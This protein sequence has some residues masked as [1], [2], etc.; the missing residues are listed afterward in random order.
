MSTTTLYEATPQ[1]GTV[2]TTNL[3]SLYSNNTAFTSGVVNSSVYSVNG[4][5]GVTVDPTTGNVLVSIGQPVAT[6]DNVTFANVTATGNIATNGNLTLNA[7]QGPSNSV[8]T[9]NYSSNQ[10]SLFWDG[11][12]WN[13]ANQVTIED[14]LTQQPKGVQGRIAGNDYWFVG[15]YS[16][17]GSSS[18]D[19][20]MVIASGNNGDEPIYVR[21]YTGS[22][23]PFPAGNTITRQL[24]LLDASGNTVLPVSLQLNGSTSGS[25]KIASPAI[26][27]TQSYTLPTALPASNGYVLSSTT[28]GTLSWVDKLSGDVVGPASATDNALTRFD[29]T[30]GKLIQN[31]NAILSD[32]GDLSIAGDLTVTGNDIKSSSATALT[33]SGADVAVAG[34]LTVTGQD[35]TA[36]SNNIII[37]RDVG[38]IS[39]VFNPLTLRMT[40]S[41]TPA[42]GIGTSLV[43]ETETAVGV[44]TQAG[45]IQLQST[46]ITPGSESFNMNFR[47]R[48]AGADIGRMTLDN[49]GNLQFDGDL[50]V[51]GND[52]KSSSATALTLSG[53]NVAIAGDL[54]VTGNDIKSSSA[55]ALTLSGANVAIAGDLTV[56]GNDIK[57]SSATALTLSGANVAIAGDLTVTGG[58]VT[59]AGST[60]GTVALNAPAIAGTQNYTLP[61]ALPAS[62]GYVLSSTTGGVMSWTATAPGAGDVVGPASA[63]DNALARFDGTTGKLI[64]NSTAILSDTGDLSISG[65]L[66]VTGQDITAG[67]NNIIIGRNVGATGSIFYPLTSRLTT[68]GTPAVGIGTGL[69]FETETAVG[70]NTQSGAIQL[71]STSIT[72]GSES[73]NMNFR[74]ISSGVD[75]NRM[76][77]DNTGNLQIDGDLTVSGNDIKSSSATA[78]T[79]SGANV[80]VIGTLDVQG[81]TITRSTGALNITTGAA[82]GDIT[83]DPNG[84][85]NIVCTLASGGNLTNTTNYLRGTVGN[86]T[87]LSNGDIYGF[88]SGAATSYRGALITNEDNTAKAPGVILR[89]Y[90]GGSFGS[91]LTRPQFAFER[92]RGTLASPTALQSGDLIGGFSG[93]GYTST[94]WLRDISGATTFP[95][96]INLS[97]TENW[98][99]NTNVGTGFSVVLMPSATTYT[100]PGVLQTSLSVNPQSSSIR[101]DGLVLQNK[102]STS[103]VVNFN[104]SARSLTMNGPS[105]EVLLLAGDVNIMQ[106]ASTWQSALSPGF[107]YTGLMSSSTQTNTGSYFEMSSRWKAS[108]GTS[109]YS[110]P[111]SGWGLGRF[112]F[113]A[114]VSTTGTSQ[115]NAGA[116]QAIATENWD[117]THYGSK[118]VFSAYKLGTGGV[119]NILDM[120]PE[121]TTITSDAITLESSSGADYLVLNANTA[122]FSVP[123]TT[124]LTS[125]TISEGT[126]YT[127]AA[128]VNN[129]LNIQ[130][131]ALAGGTTV[132][133]LANLTGNTR[134]ASYNILVFNNTGTGTPIQVKNTRI[135]TNNLMTH[136]ITT[137][138]R[139]II[140][141]YVVGDYA[142]ATHLQIP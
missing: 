87:V 127:P 14:N 137:G 77:L 109:T 138:N 30:T 142:T 23:T 93:N 74:L 86:S 123:V 78:L 27:G 51:T 101:T 65:D 135:N 21:Q 76:V 42:V 79:L 19:G 111:Q 8:I 118:L 45:I 46:S 9:A 57:S 31:S 122:K 35:I 124:E 72:P 70:V 83:L 15:G 82:N 28:S 128:T 17:S 20:A 94:G 106:A 73:F 22:G 3:T 112:G 59:L 25:V 16:I 95:A 37:S 139:I 62:N 47:L 1:T 24:T 75:T 2:S 90:S 129:N 40:T 140:N 125:A 97:T 12:L 120:A 26:A 132:F 130:I 50:T 68:S 49:A 134:G 34:D 56:T 67:S 103:T 102:A 71:Q 81:G 69:S 11:T 10:S 121:T 84:T 33:L 141:A 66:T 63:T 39:S 89:G 43:F 85:G 92:A 131:N 6:T 105:S 54:T 44:N 32:T 91:P 104:N 117:S 116:I 115:Q 113:S 7:D 96:I 4:G 18:N 58:T 114:D 133:D 52:I 64:Q 136:T 53:A 60:S 13:F 98:V 126:T 80:A 88:T 108:S 107:K 5:T 41:G 100:S 55:T 99:S 48:S 29:G 119:V 110:P 61:T 36:G 38:S